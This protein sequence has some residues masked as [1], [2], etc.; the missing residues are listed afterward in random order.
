ELDSLMTGPSLKISK[1][2]SSLTE[3]ELNDIEAQTERLSRYELG[4]KVSKDQNSGKDRKEITY[5]QINPFIKNINT[6]RQRHDKVKDVIKQALGNTKFEMEIPETEFMTKVFPVIVTHLDKDKMLEFGQ[7]KINTITQNIGNAKIEMHR[8]KSNSLL[9]ANMGKLTT[10]TITIE[11]DNQADL[12][13]AREL[14]GI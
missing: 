8:Q 13:E 7:N 3:R 11:A 2:V 12:T 5:Q 1:M 10:I 9:K 6:L 4:E 14:I